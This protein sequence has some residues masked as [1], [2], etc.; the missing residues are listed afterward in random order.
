MLIREPAVA[1]T[2]YPRDPREL[3]EAVR[4][5]AEPVP[6]P[7][8]ARA[9][10]VPHAG[11]VYSG[12]VAG[13]VISAL[14]V[15]GEVLILGPNHTG[16]G[17]PLSLF[18]EGKWSTPLGE[19]EIA[20]RLNRELLQG[21]SG[22]TEE[23]RAHGGEHSAEVQVPFLQVRDAQVR[24]SVLIIRTGDLEALLEVGREIARVIESS[25]D[26]VLIL[27][28]SDMTH[29]E[30]QERAMEKDHLAI[31]EILRVDPEG[32]HR[33]VRER[34]ISMCGIS[35]VVVAL[36]A[37]RDLGATTAELLEYRTSGDE[38]GDFDA[39]V[40]YAGILIE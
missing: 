1:G 35:P 34:E 21:V 32:L 5:Y 2:F 10:V 28:S 15:P 12:P 33:V 9:A 11:Y 31:D 27:A 17:T 37:A 23:T 26:P 14:Q 7:R 25:P 3:R 22:L 36:K 39:V 29:F 40:G 4:R 30:P 38:T 16:L 6:S 18:P 20:P 24:I 8:S 13:K 19:V